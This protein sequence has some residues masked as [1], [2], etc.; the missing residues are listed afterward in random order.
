MSKIQYSISSPLSGF[1]ILLLV[2]LSSVG[3]P[4]MPSFLR[5]LFNNTLFK[6]GYMTLLLF[7]F[8]YKPIVAFALALAFLLLLQTINNYNQFINDST[9]TLNI[10]DLTKGL[11]NSASDAMTE[12]VSDTESVLTKISD[13]VV[14]GSIRVKAA[15]KSNT[16]ANESFE[17]FN[18]L[19]ANESANESDNG[20]DNE[21]ANGSDN[22]SDNGADNFTS[23][24][25]PFDMNISPMA[26]YPEDKEEYNFYSQTAALPNN[27]SYDSKYDLNYDPVEQLTYTKELVKKPNS[28]IKRT[29]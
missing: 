26:Y 11:V 6:L 18:E 15:N 10:H 8:K 16:A 5:T 4:K 3:T 28:V 23:I 12:L 21:S 17:D 29:N 2:F 7:I 14:N 20:S 19:F 22:E 27:K 24:E 25:E 9:D 1:F 13:A